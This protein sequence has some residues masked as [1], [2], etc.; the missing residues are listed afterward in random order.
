MRTESAKA[1]GD[2]IF[3][4]ILCRWG[5]VGEIVSDNGSPYVAALDMLSDKYG[6]NHIRIAPYNSRAN[7]QV[8][9]RHRD[10]REALMKTAP[11]PSKWFD[12]AHAVF[13]AERITVSR[14]TGHSPFFIA[15]G[16]EPLHPFDHVE[17][18]YM[19]EVMSKTSPAELLA[20][21]ARQL[22]KRPG[23]LARAKE[24]V[25]KARFTSIKAFE[26]LYK[27]T[28]K[29]FDFAPGNLVL[30]RNSKIEMELDKKAKPRYLGPYV[31]IRRTK[32]GAYIVAEVDGSVAK[33]KIAAFRVIPYH[34]RKAI[35]VTI[36]ELTE[37]EEEQLDAIARD[38]Q[39]LEESDPAASEEEE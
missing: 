30:I 20:I 4:D 35:D 37:M 33:T 24:L 31:V 28:I 29:D 17:A 15:H 36:S 22:L 27:N 19:V 39:Q 21:R 8:E 16:V 11:D 38:S 23:D 18:T 32:G 25:L 2:F 7:G 10:V 6:I 5:A 14:A 26:D 9:R 13:W 1:L 34:P 3:R 12:V